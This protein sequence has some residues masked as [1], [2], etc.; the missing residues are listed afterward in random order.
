VENIEIYVLTYLVMAISAISLR[1]G[2][3]PLLNKERGDK[4]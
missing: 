4:A 2:I 1:N 3:T